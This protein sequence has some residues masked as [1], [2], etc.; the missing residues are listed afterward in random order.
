MR[1][2]Y[3]VQFYNGS[4]FQT[5][6]SLREAKRLAGGYAS[7]QDNVERRTWGVYR[8]RRDLAADRYGDAAHLSHACILRVTQEEAIDLGATP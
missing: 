6:T 2:L 4:T 8:T 3:L 5:A 1:Y 7:E